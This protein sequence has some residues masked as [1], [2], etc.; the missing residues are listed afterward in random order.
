M[1]NFR[2]VVSVLELPLTNFSSDTIEALQQFI[3]DG[4]QVTAVDFAGE[5]SRND[6]VLVI[7]SAHR[8]SKRR[9]SKT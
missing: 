9:R 4:S 2:V 8:K 1:M 7:G 3:V 5:N 6:E